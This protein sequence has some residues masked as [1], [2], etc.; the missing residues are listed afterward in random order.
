MSQQ[1]KLNENWEKYRK[2][3]ED[4]KEGFCGACMAI[5]LAFAGIGASAYGSSGS[6]RNHKSSKKWSLRIGIISILKALI[7]SP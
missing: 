7:E 5:P 6:R 3:N 2:N 4:V 1:L